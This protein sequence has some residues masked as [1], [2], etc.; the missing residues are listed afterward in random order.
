MSVVFVHLYA[1]LAEFFLETPEITFRGQFCTLHQ[2]ST[3]Q[4][5]CHWN[6]CHWET[7]CHDTWPKALYSGCLGVCEAATPTTLQ[8]ASPISCY[9]WPLWCICCIW[10]PIQTIHQCFLSIMY[11]KKENQTLNGDHLRGEIVAGHPHCCIHQACPYCNITISNLLVIIAFSEHLT[12][13]GTL[14]PLKWQQGPL[15]VAL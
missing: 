10:T 15:L 3:G 5:W 6:Q 14:F 4:T 8:L 9:S 12:K 2:T 1:M 7:F 11:C 13:H